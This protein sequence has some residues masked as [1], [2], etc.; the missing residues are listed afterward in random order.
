MR[1]WSP[2]LSRALGVLLGAALV[3]PPGAIAHAAGVPVK[4]GV[5]SQGPISPQAMYQIEQVVGEI[6]GVTVVPIVPPGDLLACVRRFV[7][8]ERD[9][10]LD[11]LVVVSLPPDL[12]KVER[13]SREAS[14]S[15]SYDIYTLDLSTLAEDRHKFTFSDSEPVTG[16]MAAILAIPADLLAERTTG[17]KLISGNSWQAFQAVQAR[18]EAK[19]LAATRLY[20]AGASIR[21]TRPLDPAQCA[22]R[23]LDAGEAD[24]A[25]AVFKSAG[26][27]NPQAS[28]QIDKMIANA[29]DQIR[30][31]RAESL[32]GAAL[33][34]IAGGDPDTAGTILASY[35]KE[36]AAQSSNAAALRNAIAAIRPSAPDAIDERTLREYVPGLDRAAF[37][38]TLKRAFASRAGTEPAAVEL[39]PSGV[40]IEDQRAAE[41]VRTQIDL[42]A[43]ALAESAWLMSVKCGCEATATLK[44]GPAGAVLLQARSGP[45]SRSRQVGLP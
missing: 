34:A 24:A 5:G 28:A 43:A 10:R 29:R 32:F 35:E 3:L 44:A 20:I 13:D 18:I 17:A 6:P 27:D 21:N 8:G 26:F 16:G 42:Y 30:Q 14:F 31:T 41:G 23:L 33:G 19:L 40:E 22:Q 37:V 39:D 7:A 11:G 38:A 2:A 15:G 1:S 25:I 4:I 12:F 9:D 36:P 45:S